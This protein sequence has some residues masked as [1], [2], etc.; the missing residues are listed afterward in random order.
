MNR[1]CDME[2]V[3]P[4]IKLA[5]DAIRSYITKGVMPSLPPI[6]LS[7][8]LE[9]KKGVFVSIKKEGLLRGCIGTIEPCKKNVAEEIIHNAISA[10]TEDP[11]FPPITSDELDHLTIFVDLL[12]SLEKV[13]DLSQLDPKKYGILATCKNKKGLLLP[14]L[15]GIDTVEEQINIAK[16]KAGIKP[17]ESVNF[18][19]FE[20]KR[21]KEKP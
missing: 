19:R 16:K 2:T 11:R 1:Y 21:Y 10:S 4:I 5:K 17:Y 9:E 20:V 6:G 18:Q 15:E 14:N 7:N 3:H 12:S 8:E 13:T